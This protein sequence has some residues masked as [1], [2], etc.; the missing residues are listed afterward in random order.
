MHMLSWNSSAE[1]PGDVLALT[2]EAD[3][4]TMGL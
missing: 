4:F 1:R 2:A 3:T